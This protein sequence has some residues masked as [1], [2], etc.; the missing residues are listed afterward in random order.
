MDTK[1]RFRIADSPD[2]FEAIHRLNYRTFVE[3]IPQHPANPERRIGEVRLLAIDPGHRRSQVLPGLCHLL[4]EQC[5]ARGLDLL[6]VSA[7]TRQ[8]RLYEHLGFVP[9]GPLVGH[10]GARFQPMCLTFERYRE[11]LRGYVWRRTGWFAG[12][13]ADGVP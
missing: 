7:T 6:I 11:V 2:E 5:L 10:E 13:A 8:R 12:R 4:E 1:L 9:F 3:E